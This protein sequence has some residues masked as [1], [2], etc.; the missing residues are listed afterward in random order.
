LSESGYR[1]DLRRPVGGNDSR[2]ERRESEKLVARA[3]STGIV[4]R[5][6][7]THQVAQKRLEF[8]RRAT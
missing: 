6:S 3:T 7:A 4:S 8:R 1:I 5:E 2:D